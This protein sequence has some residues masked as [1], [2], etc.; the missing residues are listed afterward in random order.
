M[1]SSFGLAGRR[2]VYFIFEIG[3][4]PGGYAASISDRYL[5]NSSFAGALLKSYIL[6]DSL[7]RN[8]S[9]EIDIDLRPVAVFD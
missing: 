1:N 2:I 4:P 9:A 5:A 7:V 8:V 3:D 6:D